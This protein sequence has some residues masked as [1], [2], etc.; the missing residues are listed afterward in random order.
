MRIVDAIDLFKTQYRAFSMM[1][2]EGARTLSIEVTSIESPPPADKLLGASDDIVIIPPFGRCVNAIRRGARTEAFVLMLDLKGPAGIDSAIMAATR[3][4]HF[5]YA[6]PMIGDK[7]YAESFEFLL[8]MGVRIYPLPYFPSAAVLENTDILQQTT[9]NRTRE[10]VAV[11]AGSIWGDRQDFLARLAAAALPGSVIIRQGLA[12]QDYLTFLRR[13]LVGLDFSGREAVTYRFA[14]TLL[15][16]AAC[17]CQRRSFFVLPPCPTPGSDLVQFTTAEE[18]IEIT[19]SL[20]AE[21]ERALATGINGNS[22]YNAT[23]NPVEFCSY[24]LRI[25]RGD[26]EPMT[27]IPPQEMFWSGWGTDNGISHPLWESA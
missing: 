8:G 7:R 3:L 17:V 14:E 22:W 15:S 23:Q 21:P 25:A 12:P 24:V 6:S 9:L 1:L 16:G 20:L 11:Y 2:L 26:L 13:A 10:P 5:A 18:L 4:E 19:H 27:H